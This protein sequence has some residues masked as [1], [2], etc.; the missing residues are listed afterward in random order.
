[1]RQ[2]F[3]VEFDEENIHVNTLSTIVLLHFD[4]KN[5]IEFIKYEGNKMKNH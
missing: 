5:T 2:I 1:M 4:I 3:N